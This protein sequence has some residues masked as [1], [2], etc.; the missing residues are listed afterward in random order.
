MKKQ[1]LKQ[2]IKEEIL[3][4]LKE[5]ND[6][7][8]ETLRIKSLIKSLRQSKEGNKYHTPFPNVELVANKVFNTLAIKGEYFFPKKS[9]A[10]IESQDNTDNFLKIWKEH[11]KGDG[12]INKISSF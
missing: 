12:N 7:T 6:E 2:L 5:N 9:E 8:L 1:Q 3:K 10:E 4:V 11:F